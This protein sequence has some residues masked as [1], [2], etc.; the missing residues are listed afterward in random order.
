MKPLL[1][2]SSWISLCLVVFGCSGTVSTIDPQ[3]SGIDVAIGDARADHHAPAHDTVTLDISV[4]RQGCSATGCAAGSLCCIPTQSCVQESDS[5][6]CPPPSA[7]AGVGTLD[8]IRCSSRRDCPT[9]QVCAPV[10]THG[11][12]VPLVGLCREE[13]VCDSRCAGDCRGCNC[14]GDTVDL[15]DA[16]RA[17]VFARSGACGSG[18]QPDSGTGEISCGNDDQCPSGQSCCAFRG[19]CVPTGCSECCLPPKSGQPYPCRGDFDCDRS[20]ERCVFPGS[21]PCSPV[22]RCL[23][24]TTM[25]CNGVFAPVCG[26]NDVTYVNPCEA[27]RQNVGIVHDG[28]C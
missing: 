6:A 8:G 25:N 13:S 12:G 2:W 28:P 3:D 19:S 11:C 24:R 9:G 18:S 1:S 5:S 23:P 22:G 14:L 15:R 27:Q 20:S 4:V 16:C 17:G 21:V 7:D 10:V 26:C